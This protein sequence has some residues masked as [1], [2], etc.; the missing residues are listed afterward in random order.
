MP[1]T[2]PTG[3]PQISKNSDFA[4]FADW[5]D[6]YEPGLGE[7]FIAWVPA[8]STTPDVP[9]QLHSATYG[10]P[11]HNSAYSWFSVWFAQAE[12]GPAIGGTIAKGIGGISSK[13]PGALQAAGQGI[14]QVPGA[15][16]IGQL[17]LSDFLGRLSQA[18]TWIRVGEVLLGLALIIVGLAKLTGTGEIAK[19]AA[20]VAAK[21]G[22]A[23]A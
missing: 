12:I 15:K 1:R 19:Q 23:A 2:G 6:F 18:S 3:P 4:E 14:G 8:H 22:L 10:K 11:P 16:A 20:K 17:S 7:Q 9:V 13:I 21:T 5:L